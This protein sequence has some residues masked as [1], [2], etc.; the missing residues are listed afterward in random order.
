MNEGTK[1]FTKKAYINIYKKLEVKESNL[2]E[3]WLETII[4]FEN[5]KIDNSEDGMDESIEES[6]NE[7]IGKDKYTAL[8]EYE[9]DEWR[10][11]DVYSFKENELVLVFR[12]GGSCAHV[13]YD[14]LTKI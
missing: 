1:T 11:V 13:E 14:L 6:I 4:P 10:G 9:L 3:R 2:F 7:N 8:G 12:D 5:F